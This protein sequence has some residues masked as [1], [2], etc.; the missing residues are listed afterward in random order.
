MRK[1]KQITGNLKLVYLNALVVVYVEKI[2]KNTSLDEN[3]V[4][5][6][7]IDFAVATINLYNS[8]IKDHI[9]HEL[10]FVNLF[11]LA[12]QCVKI[13]DSI[14]L[15]IIEKRVEQELKLEEAIV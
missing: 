15:L 1:K 5:D 14:D 12:N 11:D 3:Q 2:N 7:G 6:N 9:S 13:E 10:Y 8:N 4:I